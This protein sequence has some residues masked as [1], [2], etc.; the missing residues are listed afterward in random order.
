MRKILPFYNFINH[1]T[2]S[3]F[4][5]LFSISRIYV[6]KFL[7]ENENTAAEIF[8][9]KYTPLYADAGSVAP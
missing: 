3:R 6:G 9:S 8:L 5:E 1:Q 4:L 2:S 7:N